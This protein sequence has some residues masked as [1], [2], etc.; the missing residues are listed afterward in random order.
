MLPIRDFWVIVVF[1]LLSIY[2]QNGVI[3]FL[4]KQRQNYTNYHT[5]KYLGNVSKAKQKKKEYI[6]FTVPWVF[7]T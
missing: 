7:G 1:S 2:S 5:G 6:H 4:K 3:F